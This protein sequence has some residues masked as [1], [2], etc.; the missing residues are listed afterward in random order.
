M[1][2]F[3]LRGYGGTGIALIART[4]GVLPGS[5]HHF[6]ATKEDLA[7]AVLQKRL[8]LLEPV[9]LEPI[10]ARID[11]PIERVFG[12]LD[13]YRTMLGLT[14]FEHGC[15]IGNL[16]LELAESHPNLRALIGANFEKWWQAVTQCFREASDRF[17]PDTDPERLGIF[18]LTTMEGAVMLARI[19]RN[20]DAFDAA[21]VSLRETIELLLAAGGDWSA[22]RSGP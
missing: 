4:A 20:Y 11:D 3:A 18:T 8:E 13:G 7:A 15:P 19:F 16:A 9:V 2:L 22:P 10:F 5:I 12:L 14:K 21:V 17:P 1:E 6:F